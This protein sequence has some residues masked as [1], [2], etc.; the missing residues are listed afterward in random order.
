[1]YEIF[2]LVRVN[3]NSKFGP[4]TEG[5]HHSLCKM[6]FALSPFLKVHYR[7]ACN[8]C[9]FQNIGK[10]HISMIVGYFERAHSRNLSEYMQIIAMVQ[11]VF[12]ILI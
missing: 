2:L 6:Q 8:H 5:W 1:M 4:G 12:C 9:E 10:T 7:A 3:V 11:K